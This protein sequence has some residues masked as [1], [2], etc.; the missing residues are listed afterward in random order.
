LSQKEIIEIIALLSL[1]QAVEIVF[2]MAEESELS[3][4]NGKN[5]LIV[6]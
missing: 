3:Y 1:C 6:L 4:E 5:Y 2:T